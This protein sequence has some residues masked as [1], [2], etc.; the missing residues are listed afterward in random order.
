LAFVAAAYPVDEA[1]GAEGRVPSSAHRGELGV[2]MGDGRRRRREDQPLCYAAMVSRGG[3]WK[4]S[5]A[6]ATEIGRHDR[7]PRCPV[8]C[9]LAKADI[10]SVAFWRWA[11]LASST[12]SGNSCR[13]SARLTGTWVR[14]AQQFRKGI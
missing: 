9:P 2:A 8:S 10:M 12:R 14:Q 13:W 3:A 11:G 1:L 6:H 7:A 5:P 4:M